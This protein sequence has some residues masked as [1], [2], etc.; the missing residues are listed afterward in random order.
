MRMRKR[1]IAQRIRTRARRVITTIT[2]A[3]LM[4]D[5]AIG[6]CTG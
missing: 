1:K 5:T 6:M 2:E 4:R 3:I